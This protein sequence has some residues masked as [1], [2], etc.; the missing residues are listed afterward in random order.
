[1]SITPADFFISSVGL[2]TGLNGVDVKAGKLESITL[3][4]IATS[5][6][7]VRNVTNDLMSSVVS[8]VG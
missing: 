6:H 8:P 2:N 3:A 7:A 1:M 4:I 5:Q